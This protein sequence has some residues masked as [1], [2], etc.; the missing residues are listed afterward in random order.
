MRKLTGA[1]VL[2]L[3]IAGCTK[4]LTVDTAYSFTN[5][6]VNYGGNVY[7]ATYHYDTANARQVFNGTLY[8]GGANSGNYLQLNL[9]SN[10]YIIPGTYQYANTYPASASASMRFVSDTIQYIQLS[11]YVQVTSID[12]VGHKISGAFEFGGANTQNALST[13]SLTNGKFTNLNYTVQ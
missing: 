6:G 1:L 12:T 7:T 10:N 2:L 8:I 13:I 11:G 3:I 5:N 9:Q 4:S